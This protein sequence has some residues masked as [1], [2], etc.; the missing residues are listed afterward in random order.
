[1]P[2]KKGQS[3]NPGGRSSERLWHNAI[4]VALHRRLDDGRRAL[5]VVAERLVELGM[6]GDVPAL[7]EIGNRLDGKPVQ[8]VDAEVRTVRDLTD[9]ELDAQIAQYLDRL[10]LQKQ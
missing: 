4:M 3:G 6:A 5:D 10:A 1:M 9:E 8:P 7:K 2:F